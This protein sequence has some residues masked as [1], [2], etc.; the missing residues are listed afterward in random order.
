MD[1]GSE[2]ALV[3]V[4]Q[5]GIQAQGPSYK[6]LLMPGPVVGEK[7]K[8]VFISSVQSFEDMCEKIKGKLPNA[9]NASRIILEMQVADPPPG[10]EAHLVDEVWAEVEDLELFDPR[11][12][13]SLCIRAFQRP[14][15]PLPPP[16]P[17]LSTPLAVVF[18]PLP[19]LERGPETPM[20]V[21]LREDLERRAMIYTRGKSGV[22]T[23]HMRLMNEAAKQIAL[24]DPKLV[25]K[26]RRADLMKEAAD[27]VRR[28]YQFKH[29]YSRSKHAEPRE[30]PLVR[31][32]MNQSKKWNAEMRAE[33]REEVRREMA[34]VD[35]Q[36]RSK[37]LELKQTEMAGNMHRAEVVR[38][39][40]RELQREMGRLQNE[41]SDL[42]RRERRS[43]Q[44]FAKLAQ[45]N[46]RS[47]TD[48]HPGLA[49]LTAGAGQGYSQLMVHAGHG[50]QVMEGLAAMDMR[51]DLQVA[52]SAADMEQAA[53]GMAQAAV[54]AADVHTCHPHAHV[55]ELPPHPH[56]E[57]HALE[58]H[59]A[60]KGEEQPEAELQQHMHLSAP[61]QPLGALVA[62]GG[63]EAQP[64]PPESYSHGQF[65]SAHLHHQ[66]EYVSADAHH[67]AQMDP[68][69][70]PLPHSTSTDAPH[71][72]QEVVYHQ[73]HQAEISHGAEISQGGAAVVDEQEDGVEHESGDL[74]A[75]HEALVE[76]KAEDV[77]GV[78]AVSVEPAEVEQ[79]EGVADGHRAQVPASDVAHWS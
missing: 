69:S 63:E 18:S 2:L 58:A 45:E 13:T 20:E 53:T 4:T 22:L 34:Q 74:R 57:Q 32:R 27:L 62:P 50:V 75:Q 8:M 41:Q 72:H 46:S 56:H 5:K 44:R 33:R 55:A 24:R 54:V 7:R 26:G 37:D 28:H 31:K 79:V 10:Q 43:A 36:V 38:S 61:G 70:R 6:F 12:V 25:E 66:G 65:P 23:G 71:H 48:G 64:H 3:P 51:P 60:L 76:E 59:P 47:L 17:A 16:L 29:G 39:E 9:A 30:R 19:P 40:L 21:A 35:E 67:H 78:A 77:S 68:H 11:V 49:L 42:I 1:V 73:A 52:I 14:H 15:P